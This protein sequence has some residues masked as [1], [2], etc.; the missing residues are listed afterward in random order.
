MSANFYMQMTSGASYAWTTY[1]NE[2]VLPDTVKDVLSVRNEEEPVRLEFAN[3]DIEFDSRVPRQ[4]DRYGTQP[5]VVTVGGT[6]NSTARTSTV[7]WSTISDEASVTG[8]GCMVWPIPNVDLHLQYSYRVQHADLSTAASAWAGVPANIIHLIE[9]RAFQMA[10]DSGI[11]NDPVAAA[12][13]ERQVEKRTL[14]AQMNQSRQPN[15]RR[16]PTSFGMQPRGSTRG[17]WATQSITAPS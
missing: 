7:A 5:E 10:L 1:A 12:R 15:R 4:T 17:R 13:A 9:W 8:T 16:V 2:V 14:R 11:Q 6:I 3:R